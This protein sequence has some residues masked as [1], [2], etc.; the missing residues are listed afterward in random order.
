MQS[1]NI[2]R[3]EKI[4]FIKTLS[5]DL[6]IIGG[7][8]FGACALWEASLRGLKALLVDANDFGSGASA[9]SYK[10]V[11]GGIRYM[12]HLDI[13]RVRSSCKERS[14]FLRVAPHLV[15]PLPILIPTYGW[16]NLGKPVLG[17]GMLLYDLI[18]LDRNRG[19][20]DISRHIPFTRFLSRDEVLKHF[21]DVPSDGLTGGCV[22]NDGRFYNPT[23]LVWSFIQ[24]ARENGADAIN[25]AKAKDI[26]VENNTVT[27][28]HIVDSLSN[29]SHQIQCRS[30]LNSA[31]PWAERLAG[32]FSSTHYKPSATYSRDACF[33]IKRK[34][35]SPYTLAIQGQTKDPDAVV[36]RPARHLFI[37]PWRGRSL[38]GV[39]HKVTSE[40]PEQITVTKEELNEYITEINES[41]PAL[42][43]TIDEVTM[44]NAGLVPF[45]ENN[46]DAQHL[47]YGKRS[48]VVDHAVTD[49]VDGLVSLVGIR[50]TMARSEAEKALDLLQRKLGQEPEKPRS[51]YVK[52]TGAQFSTFDSLIEQI[53]QD[54][55]GRLGEDVIK[56]LAHNY[57]SEYK[58]VLSV[59]DGNHQTI[60]SFDNT[61]VTN[62]EVVYC[63]RYEMVESLGDVVFRRTDIATA[64]NP[65]NAVLREVGELVAKEL[66]WDSS[67]IDE[68]L[69]RIKQQFP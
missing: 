13:S 29:E 7:G 58:K 56:A 1:R 54:G 11:H 16:L 63:C 57:G 26:I 44:W 62:A 36:S 35:S 4:S 10:I 52:L 8:I 5:Y 51:D 17:A 61:T 31:G 28:L 23:R 14:A 27:G 42:N 33:V 41:Y 50:Y 24:S 64:G 22:F 65:E 48:L 38:V 43:L 21:P 67:R 12:Q 68:E 69:E 34:A 25:Y 32:G 59:F 55:A 37:S 45:G 15:E 2:S 6:V 53:Q 19:I 9:N 49:N 46:E 40:K 66:E 18:T 60:K 20:T 30:I 47:S 39:W 3:K